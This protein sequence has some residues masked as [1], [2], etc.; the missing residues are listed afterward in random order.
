MESG[1]GRCHQTQSL[2]DDYLDGTTTAR[3][4]IGLISTI[5]LSSHSG[6]RLPPS[7]MVESIIRFSHGNPGSMLTTG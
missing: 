2:M 1:G 6:G 5:S 4:A 7:K 3:K